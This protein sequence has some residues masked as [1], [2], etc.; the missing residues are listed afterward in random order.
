MG[1]WGDSGMFRHWQRLGLEGET[2][3]RLVSNKSLYQDYLC[4]RKI[5]R[6]PAQTTIGD[7]PFCMAMNI[8]LDTSRLPPPFMPVQRN[9]DGIFGQLLYLCF[10]QACRGY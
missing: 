3:Q 5:L 2:F 10:K 6:T 1:A 9:Q 4:T 7:S 8:G